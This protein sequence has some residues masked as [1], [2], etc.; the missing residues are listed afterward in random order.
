[1]SQQS[2]ENINYEKILSK[3]QKSVINRQ[4]KGAF[5][6][7]Y[8]LGKEEDEDYIEHDLMMHDILRGADC[9]RIDLINALQ[10]SNFKKTKYTVKNGI[11]TIENNNDRLYQIWLSKGN[12]GSIE[13][14]YNVLTKNQTDNLT[15]WE[16]V[17]W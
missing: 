11:I 10:N 1:M 9:H 16:D 4:Q 14:F 3:I 13:D 8:R 15:I 5:Y 17:E 6:N 2:I 7:N 12:V